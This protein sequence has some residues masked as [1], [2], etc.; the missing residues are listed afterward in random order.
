MV[1]S[2]RR[3]ASAPRGRWGR[4]AAVTGP[5]S[6][7]LAS[8]G[9]PPSRAHLG[10]AAVRAEPRR[11]DPVALQ[12]VDR[13]HGRLAQDARGLHHRG[14]PLGETET[15]RGGARARRPGSLAVTK[16]NP[17]PTGSGV[18]G[19]ERRPQLRPAGRRSTAGGPRGGPAHPMAGRSGSRPGTANPRRGCSAA[20]SGS[21]VTTALRR[22][23]SSD[24]WS[25]TPAGGYA[26]IGRHRSRCVL[27]VLHLVLRQRGRDAAGPARPRRGRGAR[28]TARAGSARSARPGPLRRLRQERSELE[29]A[30]WRSG[31]GVRGWPAYRSRPRRPRR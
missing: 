17:S 5:F 7:R 23:C 27:V 10:V 20:Q 31:A 15:P 19:S 29:P 12:R 24:S 21:T 26:T 2:G 6:R 28:T 3:R 1:A 13:V 4:G 11:C 14:V 22:S 18:T 30:R 16:S 25:V 8:D 9:P